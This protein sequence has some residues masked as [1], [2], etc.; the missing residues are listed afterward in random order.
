MN[1]LKLFLKLSITLLIFFSLQGEVILRYADLFKGKIEKRIPVPKKI[2]ER[3]QLIKLQCFTKN[4]Q[5]A[6]VPQPLVCH[7]NQ[8]VGFEFKS[9]YFIHDEAES[10]LKEPGSSFLRGPPSANS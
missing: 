3:Q 2:A 10:L 1:G 4:F 9:L 8:L 5:P 6:T 7:I